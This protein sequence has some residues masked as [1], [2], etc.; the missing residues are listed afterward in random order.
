MNITG[1][2]LAGGQSRRMGRDKALLEIGGVPVVSRVAAEL[3]RV[4]G[5]IAVISSR[6]E[7]YRFLG[8][9]VIPDP[10][11]FAG[12]GPLAGIRAGLAWAGTEWCVVCACDLPF[13]SAET[14][15]VLLKAVAADEDWRGR[16]A[17][18]SNKAFGKA[19]GQA[20]EQIPPMLPSVL[21]AIPVAPGGRAQPL[22]AVYHR[23]LLPSIDAELEAGRSRVMGWLE[24]V[25]AV[26]VPLEEAAGS[27]HGAG[28]PLLNMNSPEDYER[29]RLL[30]GGQENGK[31]SPPEGNG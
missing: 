17:A 2:I 26:Y 27:R 23:S 22:L 15:R 24:Q 18:S 8:V 29:A 13:A 9:P 16:A 31:N 19:I 4:A 1:I 25:P 11:A 5:R 30:S 3:S 21:A 14:I 12:R 20:S 6:E 28:D 10:E 7:D